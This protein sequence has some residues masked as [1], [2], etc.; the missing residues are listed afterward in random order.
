MR[1]AS[2]FQRASVV[3]L[4]IAGAVIAGATAGESAAGVA[5]AG[6]DV[7]RSANLFGDLKA[8]E[9]PGVRE[10]LLAK[11]LKTVAYAG[12]FTPTRETPWTTGNVRIFLYIVSGHGVVR[13]GNS[14]TEAG[15]GD[16]FVIPKG[17][18]HAVR[19]T[20]GTLRAIYFEDR[21]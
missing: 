16:F 15:P 3:L 7:V 18:R 10:H 21:T 9:I 5:A 12:E 6:S 20:S 19:A 4:I 14:R 11:G 13:V 8:C 1:T 2:G 17:E